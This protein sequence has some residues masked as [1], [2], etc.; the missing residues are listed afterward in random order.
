MS[1]DPYRPNEGGNSL[2]LDF[3]F[4]YQMRIVFVF[5]SGERVKIF[6]TG[7]LLPTFEEG[8]VCI[9]SGGPYGP[10]GG[11]TFQYWTV[12]ANIRGGYCFLFCIWGPLRAQ[13]K[14]ELFNTGLLLPTFQEGTFCFVSG[15]PYGPK[16]G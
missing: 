4:Q 11:E 6:N 16:G 9:M 13:R 7:L 3:Y 5:V 15:G 10:N 1:G 12:I 8:T 2:I 14:G